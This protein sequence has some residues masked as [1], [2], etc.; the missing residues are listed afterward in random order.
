MKPTR[1][2]VIRIECLDF[3]DIA[4]MSNREVID[5]FRYV[6]RLYKKPIIPRKVRYDA[7][8]VSRTP[9]SITVHL[10][11]DGRDTARVSFTPGPSFHSA[12]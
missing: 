6:S 3:E 12:R 7:A 11:L 4:R 8:G 2:P 9:T 1:I 10:R 5:H